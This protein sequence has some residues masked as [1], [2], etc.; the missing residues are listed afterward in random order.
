MRGRRSLATMTRGDV[1]SL[2]LALV[3]GQVMIA[4]SGFAGDTGG[5]C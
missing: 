2:S 4:V 1:L 5:E 3:E